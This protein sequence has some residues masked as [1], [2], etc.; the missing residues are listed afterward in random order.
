MPNC[1]R[2]RQ[3]PRAGSDTQAGV[4][5][6]NVFPMESCSLA[7]L[8]AVWNERIHLRTDFQREHLGKKIEEI[9]HAYA[10]S[11][12]IVPGSSAPW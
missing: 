6:E 8:C 7:D 2:K 5:F 3:E 12:G 10:I 1:R 11:V 9:Q 4:V